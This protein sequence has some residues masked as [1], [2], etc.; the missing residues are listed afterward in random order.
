MLAYCQLESYRHSTVYQ[1]T[2]DFKSWSLPV[3]LQLKD[4]RACCLACWT[5]SLAYI[6]L[7]LPLSSRKIFMIFF[8]CVSGYLSLRLSLADILDFYSQMSSDAAGCMTSVTDGTS[9]YWWNSQFSHHSFHSQCGP[10][11]FLLDF[12]TSSRNHFS[13]WCVNFYL[14]TL[15]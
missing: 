9:S 11:R 5:R 2:S 3:L 6:Y 8:V 1:F 4:S 14:F 7:H 10:I 13:L 15:K 12:Q